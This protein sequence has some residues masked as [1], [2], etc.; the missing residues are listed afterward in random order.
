MSCFRDGSAGGRPELEKGLQIGSGTPVSKLLAW[1]RLMFSKGYLCSR[2]PQKVGVS[3][4]PN[5][6]FIKK[7]S[8]RVDETHHGKIGDCSGLASWK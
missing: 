3:C 2:W 5:A 6:T 8:F 1:P 7:L 4:T